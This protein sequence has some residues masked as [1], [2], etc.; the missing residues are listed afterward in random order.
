MSFILGIVTA[1]ICL[2][3]IAIIKSTAR[4][5]EGHAAVLTSFGKIKTKENGEP[6]V[7][8]SGLH[9]KAPWEVIHE[10]SIM[11]R[12]LS[13]R[14]D[15]REVEILARDGT[16]VRLDP[17][18]RFSFDPRRMENF[19]FGIKRPISH[20]RELFRGLLSVEI[21]KFGGENPE[22]GSF[23]EIRRQRHVLNAHIQRTF[24]TDV[25]MKYGIQFRAVEIAEILP[26]AELAQALNSVQRV[27]AE[28]NTMLN[29]VRAEC[30]QQ[31]ASAEHSV[32]IEKLRAEAVE[33]D[34]QV[35]SEAI[36]QLH[37]TGVLD[38]YLKR[39]R[40]EA[41]SLSKTLFLNIN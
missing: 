14:E 10:F 26:P 35:A 33:T 16:L 2:V 38:A 1:A 17:Q 23:A 41:T 30:E 37:Q 24:Q 18:V 27:E 6:Y 15:E 7:M 12:V 36:A 25:G 32:H 20:L 29:R 28:N 39:R 40:D 22:E 19:V 31:I 9:L 3:V 11:E 21:G 5:E 4:V 8:S 34:I 13:I